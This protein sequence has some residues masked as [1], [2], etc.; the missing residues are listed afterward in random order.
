VK[1][2]L[3]TI[4]VTLLFLI[5]II[6][7]EGSAGKPGVNL[8]GGDY[9]APTVEIILPLTSRPIYGSAV[10]ECA[11]EENDSI[12]GLTFFVDGT[13]AQASLF[14]PLGVPYQYLWDCS[15][16]TAGRH[17]LQIEARD[18][19]GNRGLSPTLFLYRQDG[20]TPP[21]NDTIRYHTGLKP[22]QN[23]LWLLPDYTTA[24]N[25]GYGVRFFNEFSGLLHY[26]RIYVMRDSTWGVLKPEI[27][28]ATS[29]NGQPDSIIAR[30]TMSIRARGEHQ[31]WVDVDFRVPDLRIQGEF[32]VL[33]TNP[34]TSSPT[35]TLGFV[36]DDGVWRN[37]HSYVKQNGSWRLFPEGP[38]YN[39]LVETVFYY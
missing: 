10:I 6:G 13:A 21:T 12:A 33:I 29:K 16:L 18:R 30:R 35:D 1:Q 24:N 38:R 28:I 11:V 17:T 26:A 5:S 2:V 8:I 19:R 20:S 3:P 15:Q 14:T 7:C 32:F 34:S 4:A 37:N 9:Q 23:Y 31:G 25:E 27:S 36:T 39:F 22:N